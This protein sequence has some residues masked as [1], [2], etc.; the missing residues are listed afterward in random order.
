MLNPDEKRTFLRISE[1]KIRL[2]VDKNTEGAVVRSGSVNGKTYEV[3]EL[4][5]KSVSGY[6]TGI[7]INEH[8][9]YGN[10]IVVTLKDGDDT[11]A[12]AM[13]ENSKYAQTFI[14]HL[15]SVDFTKPVTIR[16]YQIAQNNGYNNIGVTLW[17]NNKRV[18]NY[19]KEYNPKTGKNK[20]KNGMQKFDFSSIEDKDER[21]IMTIKMIKWLRAELLKQIE[22]LNNEYVPDD[23]DTS[24]GLE[25][26]YKSEPI[27]ETDSDDL[28][29]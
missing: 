19:Y 17:Q 8:P 6:I 3:Y 21:K 20:L 26:D 1:G 4:V 9:E 7:N 11:Y 22:R 14:Q 18:P 28:Q 16:P 2:R 29:F 23:D 5:Y 15:P 10:S 27:T 13:G 25:E 24:E 12:L